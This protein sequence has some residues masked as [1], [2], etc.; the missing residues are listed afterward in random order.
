MYTE[1]YLALISSIATQLGVIAKHSLR[2][3]SSSGNM[4]VL[5][6]R[7][8]DTTSNRVDRSV[9]VRLYYRACSENGA[10]KNAAVVRGAC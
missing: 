8:E 2:W 9:I 1:A 10:D 3:S 6:V 5:M 7:S 4:P